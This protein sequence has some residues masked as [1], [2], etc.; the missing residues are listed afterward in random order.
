MYCKAITF[1]AGT[2]KINLK[3]QQQQTNKQKKP[4]T[5]MVWVKLRIEPQYSHILYVYFKT[6]GYHCIGV[7]YFY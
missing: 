5:K 6:C 4:E 3:K 2:T 7:G 1:L